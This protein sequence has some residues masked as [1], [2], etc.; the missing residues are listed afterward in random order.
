MSMYDPVVVVVGI[1]HCGL[2]C[3]VFFDPLTSPQPAVDSS[4]PP[5]FILML[6]VT[7]QLKENKLV[8]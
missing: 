3:G 5:R 6:G 1:L 8:R 4:A 7:K 2:A